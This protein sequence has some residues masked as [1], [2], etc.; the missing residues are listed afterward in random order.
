LALHKDDKTLEA[1]I[2]VHR[3]HITPF[4]RR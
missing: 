3:E 4:R 1:A 2:S